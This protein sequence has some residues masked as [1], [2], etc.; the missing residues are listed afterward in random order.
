MIGMPVDVE[1]V[2]EAGE[3]AEDELLELYSALVPRNLGNTGMSYGLATMDRGERITAFLA[4][5]MSGSVD[6]LRDIS[7]PQYVAYVDEFLDD[8]E[9]TPMYAT[10]PQIQQ[11]R[12]ALERERAQG[13]M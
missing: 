1:I 4:R 8:V 2:Q 9:R 7:P 3:R 13:V 10:N 6:I 11:L 12:A 5:V